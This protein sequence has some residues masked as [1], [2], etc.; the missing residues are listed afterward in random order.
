MDDDFRKVQDVLSKDKPV[1]IGRLAAGTESI[2]TGNIFTNQSLSR[3]IIQL[4]SFVAGIHTT[5]MNSVKDYAEEYMGAIKSS[6][7]LGVWKGPKYIGIKSIYDAI[8]KEHPDV[9]KIDARSI[10]PYYFMDKEDYSFNKIIKN[11]RLLIVSSH[12]ESMK[13]QKGKLDK[14]FKKPIFENNEL[15]F[16]KPPITLAGNHNDIDWREYFRRL[17]NDVSQVSDKIDLA[18]VSCGGYGMP[19]C[20]FIKD[21]LRKSCIYVGGALQLFF[22]IKGGRW[23]AMNNINKFYNKHWIRPVQKDIP[24]NF[25][26]WEKAEGSSYW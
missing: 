23:D 21:E 25:R 13:K 3:E 18:L 19:L 20:K 6:D 26:M 7:L 12:L 17:K 15:E 5:S 1:M 11:K 16:V 22:G 9:R 14:L 4:H 10:E 24:K 2:V 8:N